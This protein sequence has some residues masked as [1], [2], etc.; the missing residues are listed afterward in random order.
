[1]HS[2]GPGEVRRIGADVERQVVGRAQSYAKHEHYTHT[3]VRPRTPSPCGRQP[4]PQR[5]LMRRIE[6][7]RVRYLALRHLPVHVVATTSTKAAKVAPLCAAFFFFSLFLSPPFGCDFV[8]Q[9]WTPRVIGAPT[10]RLP[11]YPTE[12]LSAARGEQ[13]CRPF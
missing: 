13:L 5:P 4:P 9:S 2:H 8:I 11:P 12:P 7:L 3:H 10:G 1:M 6:H